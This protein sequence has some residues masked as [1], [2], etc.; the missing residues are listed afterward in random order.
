MPECTSVRTG[1]NDDPSARPPTAGA[2]A[3]RRSRPATAPSGAA[4]VGR[5][6][7]PLSRPI[8]KLKP[9]GEYSECYCGA[10]FG[11]WKKKSHCRYCG[12]VRCPTCIDDVKIP[13]PQFGYFDPV[14]VCNF[15]TPYL[16][17]SAMSAKSLLPLP[18]KEL[19]GYIKAYGLDAEGLLEKSELV[20]LIAQTPLSAE[21]EKAFREGVPC[22]PPTN[23]REGDNMASDAR[24][25]RSESAKR[26]RENRQRVE[27]EGERTQRTR[28]MN[29]ERLAAQQRQNA[30]SGPRP[31]HQAGP[32]SWTEYPGNVRPSGG[33]FGN[34]P[35]PDL[36][37]FFGGAQRP[38]PVPHFGGFP[39]GTGYH[40]APSSSPSPPTFSN[41]MAPRPDGQTAW[42]DG[43]LPSWGVHGP[44]SPG[45]RSQPASSSQSPA[46][47]YPPRPSE[48]N[49]YA[50]RPR[51]RPAPA[52]ARAT[53][54]NARTAAPASSVPPASS[55][56]LNVPTLASLLSSST[57]PSTLPA[58]TLKHILSE[59]KVD[60]SNVLE[61]SELVSRVKRLLDAARSE[62]AI[63]AAANAR[64]EESTSASRPQQQQQQST[65]DEDDG[66][67]KIC[68][69][70]VVNC[71]FLECGH[72]VTCM[73]CGKL[74]ERSTR[75]CPICREPISRIVR[76]FQT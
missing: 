43:I 32:S 10:K 42:W 12:N 35:P 2:A 72:L 38:P 11:F 70:K 69:D 53:A 58:R 6:H 45:P 22:L 3:G 17:M 61:K 24:R 5:G 46:S 51:P 36:N 27:A 68:C 67:C 73:D 9:K 7:E 47:G 21:S 25:E 18:T 15:C 48:P 19:Q 37:A 66:L 13:L 56:S 75:E 62:A 23:P 60:Y 1:D 33:F 71:V 29:A 4:P 55:S 30:Y 20:N 52:P 40:S 76:T 50:P 57:D 39:Q 34:G 8:P 74:L 44:A 63:Q 49:T 59:N 26:E 31:T 41:P 65:V 14:S 28:Q 54:T 16:K 64:F